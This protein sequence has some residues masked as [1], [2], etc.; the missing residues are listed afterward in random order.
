MAKAIEV[1][2]DSGAV[3]VRANMPTAGWIGGPG[4]VMGVLN[5]NPLSRN[6]GNP[7]TP[8]IVFIYE[9]NPSTGATNWAT[10]D[11]CSGV[12]IGGGQLVVVDLKMRWQ[13]MVFYLAGASTATT[14]AEAKFPSHG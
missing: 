3:L 13:P 2:Q 11:P 5:R 4:T 6:K 12:R 8:P 14:S 7:A 1:L 9:L 10:C